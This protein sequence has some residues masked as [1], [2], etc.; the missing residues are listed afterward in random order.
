MQS[1]RWRL[2]PLQFDFVWE[3]LGVGELPYPFELRSHGQ[4]DVERA[5]LR[6]RAAQELRSMGMTRGDDLDPELKDA[7]TSL[8]RSDYVLDSVWLPV[9]T[10]GLSPVRTIAARTGHRATLAVQLPGDTEHTGGDL[11]LGDIP[12][13][14]MA[15]AVVAELPPAPPGRHPALSVPVMP[16]NQPRQDD[17]DGGVMVASSQGYDRTSR[18]RQAVEQL[19]AARHLRVGEL[20]AMF[21]DQQGRRVRSGVLRW[22]DNVD[23]GRYL[24]V[25]ERDYGGERVIVQ[26]ADANAIGQRLH[27]LR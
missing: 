7:L 16:Q 2:T 13:D 20:G 17:Y 21:R 9:E 12:A 1:V 24:M 11:L 14:A 5:H 15:P 4:D 27:A 25:N 10:P 26:P 8:V 18:E 19:T 6:R 22:F 23:D 3:G